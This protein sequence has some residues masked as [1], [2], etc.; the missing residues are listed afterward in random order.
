MASKGGRYAGFLGLSG[1]VTIALCAVGY[2]PTRNLAGEDGVAAMF[3][4]CAAGLISAALA[5]ALLSTMSA[6]TP[7]GR[8][9]RGFLA[10]IVRLA[11]VIGLGAAAVFSGAFSR[12]P[13]LFWIGVTYVALL[14][15][16]VR[17]AIL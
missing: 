6:P 5:G 13:L 4:G 16:E 8:M 14:P 11:A 1:A 3:A 12:Q 9:Q 2:V 10:M 15:L 7:E 17:L